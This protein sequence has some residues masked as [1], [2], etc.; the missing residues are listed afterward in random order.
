MKGRTISHYKIIDEIGRGGM[1]VVYSAH[2][3]RLDRAVALKFLPPHLAGSDE[4]EARF[5]REARAAAA[6]NHVN[7]CT[8]YEI[9][10]S[11]EHP[12]IAMELIEGRTLREVLE[13]GPLDPKTSVGLAIQAGGALEAAHE[14]G[15]VHRDIKSEN[16]MVT[17]DGR[18]KVTD[19]GL[20]KIRG[21]VNLTR[22]SSTLGTV[23]YMAPESIQGSDIDARADLFSFGVVIYEMLTGTLPFRG[24]YES[25]MMYSIMN[26]EP[27]PV[28]KHRPDLSS[29]LL[30]LLYRALEKDPADR[31]QSAGD[32][33]IDLK[34]IER[35]IS[36]G[37]GASRG[38]TSAPSGSAGPSGSSGGPVAGSVQR[39]ASPRGR[40]I[41]P[42][43]LVAAIAAFAAVFL[44]GPGGGPELD[45]SL[46]VV[47]PFENRTGDG[48]LDYLGDLAA[49]M[50][51]AGLTQVEEIETVPVVAVKE[52]HTASGDRRSAFDIAENAGAGTIITGSYY[53]REGDLYFSAD[54]MGAGTRKLIASSGPVSG[55]P[56]AAEEL[57]ER[58]ADGLVGRLAVHIFWNFDISQTR[59]VSFEAMKEFGIG[60][61][62]FGMD[63]AGARDHFRRAVE[64]DSTLYMARMWTATSYMN[65]GRY[66]KAE[67][68][69]RHLDGRRDELGEYGRLVLDWGFAQLEGNYASAGKILARMK[70]LVTQNMTTEYLIALNACRRNM[71]GRAIEVFERKGVERLSRYSPWALN[72]MAEACY[73]LGEYEKGLEA[74]RINSLRHPDYSG[75]VMTEAVLLAAKGD[76]AGV[77]GVIDRSFDISPHLPGRVMMAAAEALRAHGRAGASREVCERA[78]EWYRSRPSGDYRYRIARAL[79]LC[80]ESAGAL[81]L[82]EE[83]LGEHPDHIDLTGYAGAS[84]ARTGDRERA[85]SILG[86][87]YER[88]DPYL[89]GKHLFWCARI[90]AVLGD[91][92]R[93]VNLLREAYGHGHPY[94]M[95]D[96]LVIDFEPLRGYGPYEELMR[97]KG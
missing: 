38:I 73:M 80:G 26:E 84:A 69:Y 66:E 49:E 90:A 85:E 86:G 91:E 22:S 8:I 23:A 78:L 79:Y 24:D 71:P 88:D 54:I 76:L 21:A 32:M 30:H 82:F 43:V 45:E 58:L 52:Q 16:I 33:L 97:P 96:L 92:K 41:V 44:I 65:Q 20:A 93:A 4:D 10:D 39:A 60:T 77:E 36:G 12:F 3:T 57:L 70:E 14:K 72:V 81:E 15:I 13:E 35:E 42:A 83:L 74:L 68:I 19:F 37:S 48:S 46:Y 95:D 50:I 56:S 25:A 67:S 18:V 64:I 53:R 89:L 7:V 2:D 61:E 62:L 1:G 55:S 6:L 87:L 51:T 17:E 9:D 59:D 40:W 47:I 31:Y 34:R 94:S 5:L 29:E 28:Q 75:N 63:Y 11:G 27:E